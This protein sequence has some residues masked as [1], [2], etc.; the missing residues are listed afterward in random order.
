MPP[1]WHRSV[2]V[3]AE[4]APPTCRSSTAWMASSRRL[5]SRTSLRPRSSRVGRQVR[6]RQG[7]AAEI[8]E[9]GGYSRATVRARYG[10]K[11]ALLELLHGEFEPMF[12]RAQVPA[13]NGLETILGRLD[14]LAEQPKEKPELLAAFLHLAPKPWDRFKSSAR[15]CG[16]GW[17][18]TAQIPR[19]AFGRAE[20][21]LNTTG[22]ERRSREQADYYLWAWARF[23]LNPRTR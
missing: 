11:E 9:R 6:A 12:L 22:S 7:P 2:A 23:S 18:S 3:R 17:L 19:R 15:G 10:T 16:A 8:G 21:R 13:D 1:I 14:H 4:T 20:I 5:C